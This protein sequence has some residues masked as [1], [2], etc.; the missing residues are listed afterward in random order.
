M[1][2]QYTTLKIA[3]R[4][5][6]A[7]DNTTAVLDFIGYNEKAV[8]GNTIILNVL[9]W[10]FSKLIEIIHVQFSEELGERA[11]R[12]EIDFYSITPD[13]KEEKVTKCA[14]NDKA[15]TSVLHVVFGESPSQSI[16]GGSDKEDPTDTFNDVF[17]WIGLCDGNY[18]RKTFKS[19]DEKNGLYSR[20]GRR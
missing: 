10:N 17:K 11:Y 18:L 13:G 6:R 2:K 15:K 4:T 16:R 12:K 19:E 14:R 9:T 8:S 5:D 1:N 3:C 20:T 7:L